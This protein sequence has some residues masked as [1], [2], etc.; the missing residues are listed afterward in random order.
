MPIILRMHISLI[1]IYDMDLDKI[2]NFL[3]LFYQRS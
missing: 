3:K 2:Q 1:N